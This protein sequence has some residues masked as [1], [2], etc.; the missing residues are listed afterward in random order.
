MTMID[1]SK[2]INS[3]GVAVKIY[4]NQEQASVAVAQ[5]IADLIKRKQAAGEKA[6]LGL[7]T[8]A[9][10]VAVYKELIRMHR[11]EGLSFQNV[12]TFNLDEYYPMQPTAEQSYVAFMREQLFDHVDIAAEH[13]YIPDG[14]VEQGNVETYC[15]SYEQRIS[16]YGGLDVQLLGI[17]RTGHIGFNEPGSTADSLT[18]LVELN[19]VTRQDAAPAF[20]GVEQVPTHAITMG[21][22]SVAKAKEI[23]LMAWGEKKADIVK[24][25]LESAITAEV[26]AT[27]LQQMD[28]VVFV[29]DKGAAVQVANN[30]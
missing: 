14:T 3:K 11:E 18:R 22:G 26:P 8:G 19:E 30:R 13:I 29:L 1:T 24:R 6:V 16:H 4:N 15:D 25:A 7:A 2:E 17:G 23:I 27:Y 21:V 20:G 28:G 9:T 10:P 12:V 5:R